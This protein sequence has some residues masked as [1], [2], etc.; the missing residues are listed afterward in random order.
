M[1][2]KSYKQWKKISFFGIEVVISKIIYEKMN[3]NSKEDNLTFRINL[4]TQLIT[5]LD[6]FSIIMFQELILFLLYI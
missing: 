3:P 6:I 1:E 2:R 4:L 5:N